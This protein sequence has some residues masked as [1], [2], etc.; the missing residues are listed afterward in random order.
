MPL[1]AVVL[2]AVTV[3]YLAF[4][5]LRDQLLRDEVRSHQQRLDELSERVGGLTDTVRE[6][7]AEGLETIPHGQRLDELSEQ[8]GGFMDAV[9]EHV[10]ESLETIPPS[11]RRVYSFSM[12]MT[13]E[14]TR[15][16]VGITDEELSELDERVHLA[17]ERFWPA[18][19]VTIEEWD[20]HI[21]IFH[22]GRHA[23]TAYRTDIDAFSY[24]MRVWFHTFGFKVNGPTKNG[25]LEV[26]LDRDAIICRGVD[27]RFGRKAW[28]WLEAKTE[29]MYITI[30]LRAAELAPYMSPDH[31]SDDPEL[32]YENTPYRR[33]YYHEDAK[34]FGW[35]LI[36]RDMVAYQRRFDPPLSRAE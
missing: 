8:V 21:A 24:P 4:K 31:K 34:G 18:P 17:P 11:L 13:R 32:S 35:R 9:R 19:D 20:T 2:I 29:H 12:W 5:S 22:N 33:E 3:V 25:S 7:V 28:Q 6:H 36:L 27:G 15:D 26:V 14:F 10:A 16:V 30:P 23:L 1:Y